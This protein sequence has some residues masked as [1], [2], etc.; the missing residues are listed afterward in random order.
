MLHFI[1]IYVYE[2][3]VKYSYDVSFFSGTMTRTINPKCIWFGDAMPKGYNGLWW[4]RR[5]FYSL[6]NR[7]EVDTN[8]G[9][10]F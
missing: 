5:L 9:I 1:T 6:F 2:K 3:S 8:I 4:S 10:N 7:L